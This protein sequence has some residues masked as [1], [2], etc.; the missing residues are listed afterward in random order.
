MPLVRGLR[1]QPLPASVAGGL[2]R[3]VAGE[4]L[5]DKKVQA[6]PTT[7]QTL[8]ALKCEVDAVIVGRVAAAGARATGHTA[9]DRAML[10]RRGTG[11]CG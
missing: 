6:A 1:L 2:F 5:V 11:G 8:S 9:L 7:I 4:A 10:P 3:Y